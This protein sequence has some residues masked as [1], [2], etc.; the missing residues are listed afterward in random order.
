MNLNRIFDPTGSEAPELPRGTARDQRDL[1][2]S[3]GVRAVEEAA[4]EEGHVHALEIVARNRRGVHQRGFSRHSRTTGN[5]DRLSVDDARLSKG[6]GCH[7]ACRHDAGQAAHAIERL[8]KEDDALFGCVE[9]SSR[10]NLK[11]GHVVTR[12]AGIDALDQYKAAGEQPR[13]NGE[14]QRRRHFRDDEHAAHAAAGTG[15]SLSERQDG[16]RP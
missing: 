6:H 3:G 4:L 15:P 9:T 11:H 1:S 7:A 16:G 14:H 13:S 5:R 8:L 10:K 2:R 12:E